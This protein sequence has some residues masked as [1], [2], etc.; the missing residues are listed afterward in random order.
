MHDLVTRE[1]TLIRFFEESVAGFPGRVYLWEKARGA[2][3]YSGTTYQET[4]Q[5]VLR[6]A[7]GLMSLGLERGDRVALFSEGRNAWVISELAILYNGAVNVPLSVKLSEPDEIRF[8]LEHSG[9]RMVI[10]SGNQ[11]PKVRST[12]KS[13][14]MLE[15]VI[16]LDET[17]RKEDGELTCNEVL[18]AGDAFLNDKGH[19]FRERVG[20]VLPDDAANICYTSGTSADPK[21]IIL[22]HRNYFTNILQGYSLIDITPEHRTLLILPWDHAF[23]HTAGIYC[24]MG[25]GASIAS[26]QTGKT[27]IETLKNISQNIREIRPTILLSV[28]A[29]ASNFRKNIEKNIQG[30]GIV[31]AF[32]FRHALSVAYRYQKEGWNKSEGMGFLLKPLLWFYDFL[33]FR[34]IRKGFGGELQFFIGGGALLDIEYQRF[35]YALGIPMFQGYGLSEAAPVISSNTAKRHKLGS[36]GILVSGLSLRICDDKG[37]DLPA[38]AAGEIVVKGDNVMKGYWRNEEATLNT[39]REGWLF[40]GDLGHTDHQGFLHVTGRFKSLLIASDGEK[41]SPEGMEEAFCGQS[42]FISQCMLYNNQNPYTILLLYPNKERMI[43]YLAEKGFSRDSRE[44]G[45]AALARLLAE[46]QEYGPSGRYDG[47][48]PRRWLPSAVG[49][50]NEGFTEENH[51]MNSTMKIVRGRITARYE[52]LISFLYT[53]EAKMISNPKNRETIKTLLQ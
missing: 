9:A 43:S 3:N 48:F 35:F 49:V 12:R 41:F 36:S 2:A 37:N 7:A 27:Q 21:G 33:L 32:L 22:T 29:L 10:V 6:L 52:E 28:P 23:A 47:M 46:L 40:T 17:S 50:L 8:R 11:L 16:I 25:K 24:F 39:I 44:G 45:E 38:G 53:P 30:K 20:G 19:H 26:V 15:K 5:L 31:P 14:P 34:K 51:L 18:E 13:L 4:R 42:E 1:S